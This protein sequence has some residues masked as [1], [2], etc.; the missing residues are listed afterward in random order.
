[1]KFK[2]YGSPW[3]FAFKGALFLLI[4]AIS[5]IHVSGSFKVL[6]YFSAALILAMAFAV[7]GNTFILT[8][9][10]EKIVSTILA[11]CHLA[12][13]CIIFALTIKRGTTFDMTEQAAFRAL[14][15]LWIRNWFAF[16]LLTEW[17]EAIHLWVKKNAHSITIFMDSIMTAIFLIVFAYLKRCA[18]TGLLIDFY[19]MPFLFL[20]LITLLAGLGTLATAFMLDVG[21]KHSY[22]DN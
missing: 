10:K 2:K 15:L 14:T 13:A 16:F 21:N 18:E 12:F 5:F 6:G 7:F 3:Y 4:S 20:A 9:K 8:S 1:M 19:D 11:L 17:I 22:K